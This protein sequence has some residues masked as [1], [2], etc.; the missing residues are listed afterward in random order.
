MST[1]TSIRRRRP[2]RRSWSTTSP[3][4]VE[5]LTAAGYAVVTDEPLESYDRVY[6]TD[7]FG[8][9]IELMERLAG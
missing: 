4:L 8:N 5:Q 3:E 2:T 7:P 1:P 9:R 6:V